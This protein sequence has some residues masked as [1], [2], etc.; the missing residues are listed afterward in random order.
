MVR[1]AIY[2]FRKISKLLS[3]E[4]KDMRIFESWESIDKMNLDIYKKYHF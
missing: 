3:F 1:A 4:G 2:V